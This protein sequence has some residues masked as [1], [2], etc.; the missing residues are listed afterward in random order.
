MERWLSDPGAQLMPTTG[1][2]MFPFPSG[3]VPRGFFCSGGSAPWK[4][5]IAPP[6]LLNG[7][8]PI[9]L[10]GLGMGAVAGVS[11]LWSF[12][13]K[14]PEV[15]GRGGRGVNVVG[16]L[17]FLSSFCFPILECGAGSVLRAESSVSQMKKLERTVAFSRSL[18]LILPSIYIAAEWE[19]ELRSVQTAFWPLSS[20]PN[21]SLTSKGF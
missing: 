19:L 1:I 11:K 21:H 20:Y 17:W 10:M 2:I 18:I 16:L 14:F 12:C 3:P 8:F 6:S 7:P 13:L 5:Q 4:D 15:A 9:L